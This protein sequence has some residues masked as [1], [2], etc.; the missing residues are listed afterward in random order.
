MIAHAIAN[1]DEIT[2]YLIK[3]QKQ[4]F[5][6]IWDELCLCMLWVMNK[7]MPRWRSSLRI[8]HFNGVAQT[9]IGMLETFTKYIAQK[10]P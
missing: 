5:L 4:D 8:W 2:I 3:D 1:F 9:W 10:L 7:S 6:N